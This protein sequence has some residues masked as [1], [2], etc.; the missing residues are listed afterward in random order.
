VVEAW[1]HPSVTDPVRSP[2]S[3]EAQ[4]S[5]ART[6]VDEW[7][8]GGVSDAAVAPSAGLAPVALALIEE[9]RI[10]V[11]V[12]PDARSA[13]FLALGLGMATG[14]P[15][16][17]LAAP[18]DDADLLPALLEADRTGVPLIAVTIDGPDAEGR[19]VIPG[20]PMRWQ[21]GSGPGESA[22]PE[23]VRGLALAAAGRTVREATGARP[24]PVHLTLDMAGRPIRRHAT[25]A[26]AATTADAIPHDVERGL[27]VVGAG[28]GDPAAV[29][30]AARALGWPVL[31]DA[32]SGARMPTPLTIAAAD[33][34]LRGA[35]FREVH[36]PD[37]VLRLGG[38]WASDAMADALTEWAALEVVPD[39]PLG[40]TD[41]C[42]AIAERGP[43]DRPTAWLE[44]WAAAEAAAQAAIDA[45]LADIVPITEPW[46][47][48]V[49]TAQLPDGAALVTSAAMA[50][51][52][53]EWFS[54]PREGLRVLATEATGMAG[55]A[56][57]MALGAAASHSGP[58]VALIGDLAFLRDVNG[59]MAIK[60]TAGGLDCTI[61]VVDNDGAG[62]HSM[63]PLAADVPEG[64]FE[65]L[66]GAPHG[67][68]I[69][70]VA[71]AHGAPA[72]RVPKLSDFLP[73][74][75]AAMAA[76]GV[77]VVHVRT[78][79]RLNASV[80][81]RIHQSVTAVINALSQPRA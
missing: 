75:E 15:A 21:A 13:A 52:D 47:A 72:Y 31:A 23:A 28:G 60:G 48:R 18:G 12:I 35:P 43:V 41:L 46:L 7:V 80:H 4:A 40:A 9:G 11:H 38:T 54:R 34:L 25:T 44:S 22:D 14:R 1:Q 6:L 10:R 42:R 74:V 51:R 3:A 73:T 64:R 50:R 33:A 17:V 62:S 39:A 70:S 29:H 57:A 55:G 67:L 19:P 37:V 27:I 26:T 56:V 16:I 66:F 32:R 58:T 77:R 68:D 30:A 65:R 63:L 49:L 8:R 53:V 59:M 81:D 20:W 2:P 76:G 71:A 24:G 45:A 69:A 5:F 78:D 61:V 36:R 79:R